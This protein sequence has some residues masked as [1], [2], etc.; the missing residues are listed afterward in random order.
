MSKK[1]KMGFVVGKFCPLH[2]GHM[3][4]IDTALAMCDHVTIFSYTS[5]SFIGCSRENRKLWLKSIYG[6]KNTTIKVFKR[7]EVPDDDASE[8]QHRHFCADQLLK[9]SRVPDA[10]FTSEMYGTGLA[11]YLEAFFHPYGGNVDH[12]CVDLERKE[13]PISG[14]Q[15]RGFDLRNKAGY[16]HPIVA[17]SFVTKILFT[18]AESTGKSTIAASMAKRYGVEYT[19]EY[20]RELWEERRGDLT[21]EDF[22]RIGRTQ[23]ARESEAGARAV[24]DRSSQYSAVMCDTSPLTTLFY[25]LHF[26]GRAEPKLYKLAKNSLK[27]YKKIYLCTPDFEFVQDGTRQDKEF[28]TKMHLWLRDFLVGHVIPFEELTG[29]NDERMSKIDQGLLLW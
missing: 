24:M 1:Y 8:V 27:N 22:L 4:L 21:Y 11:Q 5:E 25:C 10:V 29:T 12:V 3:H 26:Y 14:T 2:V 20:G 17:S 13:Y 18:G 15:L 6:G 28:Q 9:L 23:M 16:L 19:K 7:S